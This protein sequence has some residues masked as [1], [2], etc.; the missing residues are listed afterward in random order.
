M[1]KKLTIVP[2]IVPSVPSTPAHNSLSQQGGEGWIE[3]IIEPGPEQELEDLQ[4][5]KDQL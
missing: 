2:P 5:V 1:S 4:R 3:E